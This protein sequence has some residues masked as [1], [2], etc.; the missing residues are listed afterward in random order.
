MGDSTIDALNE[1]LDELT[2]LGHELPEF[3]ELQEKIA[4]LRARAEG[5]VR[6][7]PLIAIG[8]AVVVGYL[9]GRLLSSDDDD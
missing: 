9:I 5:L 3:D 7:H 1:K 4:E 6:E 8:A 2:D